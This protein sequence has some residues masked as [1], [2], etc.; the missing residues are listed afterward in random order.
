MKSIAL[1]N[2]FFNSLIR[3]QTPLIK[4]ITIVNLFILIVQIFI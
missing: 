3:K 1:E 2:F 4:L